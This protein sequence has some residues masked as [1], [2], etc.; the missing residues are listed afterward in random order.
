[1]NRILNPVLPSLIITLLL[2]LGSLTL[3]KAQPFSSQEADYYSIEKVPIPDGIV[4]EVGGL[5]FDDNGNLA[6]STRRGEIWR[7]GNPASKSPTFSRFA[8]G[9][10]E[11][12]GL[13]YKEGAYYLSQRAELSKI[14]DTD[15]DGKADKYEPVYVWPLEGNYHEYSYGPVFLPDGDM[16]VTLNLGWIGR[17]ASLSKWRGWMLRITPEGEMTPIATGMRSPAGFGLNAAGDIFYTENQGDWVGSGRMTHVEVGDFVGNPAGLKWTGEEESPLSLKVEDIIDTLGYTLY[18]YGQV[19]PA[20]KPPSVWFPHTLMGIST[21]DVLLVDNDK[22]G[23]FEGQLLVGDQGHSKIMRVFQEK[24]N[25]TYQGACFGFREG[26]SSGVLRITWG[27]EDDIY[28]GMTSRGW[29]STGKAPFGLER[30]VASENTPFEMQKIEAQPDGF[31]ITFTEEIDPTTAQDPASYQLTDFTYKYHHI[32]GSPTINQ[33]TKMIHHVM[34]GEDGKSARLYFPDMREGYVYEVNAKG[35][36][37]T[38][39]EAILHPVAYYTLNFIPEGEGM[40]MNMAS[41]SEASATSMAASPKRITSMPTSWSSGPDQTVDIGTLPGL[42]Y[43][44]AEIRVK[45][46]EKVRLNFNNNDD[47]LHNLLIVKPGK[48]DAI[49]QLAME[50][51]LQGQE[52][53][54]VPASADVLYH[55]G[56][57]QPESIEIIYFEAPSTPGKYEYV[58][59]YPGHSQLMRGVLV[60]E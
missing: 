31:L 40:D 22:F 54:Y 26:F 19:I 2:S 58:C 44:V 8:H 52:K 30:L 27:P 48:A 36:K 16:L 15:Q 12:L 41:I 21:S 6:V 45:A 25:D 59:T 18:E 9:L 39:D 47:M 13:A 50:L 7:I 11:P 33:Q 57:L 56:L 17:G 35:V 24:V 34:L 4:L 43:D 5:A 46:G 29:A 3:L 55:T 42:K 1:M 38:K 10:H 60:V 20:I 32:Y 53:G 49:G 28:V 51:G 14:Q 23:P 37:S